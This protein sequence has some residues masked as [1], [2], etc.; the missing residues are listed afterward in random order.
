MESILDF[1]RDYYALQKKY[2][3]RS[4][5]FFNMAALVCLPCLH[6]PFIAVRIETLKT[7]QNT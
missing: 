6:E 3:V 5:F 7:E 4:V 2:T 1:F